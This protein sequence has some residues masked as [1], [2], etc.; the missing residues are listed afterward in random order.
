[1][2]FLFEIQSGSLQNLESLITNGKRSELL[3]ILNKK[4]K[5][6]ERE[7]NSCLE[8]NEYSNLNFSEGDLSYL[9]L[10]KNGIYLEY[11]LSYAERACNPI[12]N[13]DKKELSSFFPITLF[14]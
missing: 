1:M 4:L 13:I 3:M 8:R 11:S 14:E 10:Q 12:V 9:Q 2:Q 7:L 5:L 6:E